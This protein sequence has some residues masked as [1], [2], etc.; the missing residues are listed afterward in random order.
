ME[1]LQIFK[2]LSDAH[3]RLFFRKANSTIWI[4]VLIKNVQF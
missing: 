1:M 4:L 2:A 3:I